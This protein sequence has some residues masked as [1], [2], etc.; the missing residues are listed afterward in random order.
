M[1][2]LGL[3]EKSKSIVCQ[4]ACLENKVVSFHTYVM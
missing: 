2:M 4:T 3:Y 1:I